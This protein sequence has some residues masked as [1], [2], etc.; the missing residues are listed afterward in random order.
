[1]F[2][3][4]ALRLK[5][6]AARLDELRSCLNIEGTQEEIGALESKMAEPNFWDSPEAAQKH[7]QKLKNLKTTISAPEALRSELEDAQVLV[8]LAQQEGEESMDA[9][10]AEITE[11]VESHLAR[12]EL[13]S[14]L[15]D[16][17]DGKNAIIN[18][19]PG[20]GG[21]ESCDWADMLYRMI[22]RFCERHEFDVEV[23]EYQPGEEAGLKSAALLVTGSM[24]Y[25]N[26]KS[27]SGVH[28]LV[29]IS[30]FDASRRRHTSFAAIEVLTEVDDNI[31][32]EIREEDL[33][34]DVYRASGA[35]GQHINKTSSA[36]RLTH[37]PT[38]IVVA[39][40]MERSQHRNRAM[41][42]QMIKAKLYDVEMLKQQ[43]ELDKQRDGQQDVAWG[44]QIRSYVLHPYQM[45]K[46]HRTNTEV[47]NVDRVL[48]GDLDKFIEAYLKWKLEQR[49]RN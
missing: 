2:E 19:H 21:T 3:E 7:V 36:V 27:E 39:C 41:A 10:I 29:R 31:E 8:E 14:L 11:S 48:D 35:G 24:V 33:K 45:V 26:M 43:A 23:L 4:E 12:V 32:I 30:P 42:E 18:I 20:A 13:E 46:D 49:S 47:G 38:G 16:P 22:R 37:T 34:M 1:M 15:S 44:S 40:Q 25:G 17:R 5:D 6:F 9:E 28:R